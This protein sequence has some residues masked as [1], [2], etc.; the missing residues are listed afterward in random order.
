MPPPPPL[1]SPS[2]YPME[3]DMNF[4]QNSASLVLVGSYKFLNGPA[5]Q[6]VQAGVQISTDFECTL[7]QLS[8]HGVTVYLPS[9]ESWP[10]ENNKNNNIFSVFRPR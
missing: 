10:N 6:Q 9:F 1:P 8:T 2:S 5:P 7:Y 4:P 3:I